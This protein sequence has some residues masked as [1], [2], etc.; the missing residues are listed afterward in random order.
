VRGVL[1]MEVNN[2]RAGS[3]YR[4]EQK[5]GF[6]V[7]C[8]RWLGCIGRRNCEA[9]VRRAC[10]SP[11]KPLTSSLSDGNRVGDIC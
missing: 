8:V 6:M 1:P 2:V 5:T 4:S 7:Y 10:V 11:G 9:L 3:E